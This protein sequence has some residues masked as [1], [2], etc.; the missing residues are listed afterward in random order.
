MDY[1]LEVKHPQK[2]NIEKYLGIFFDKKQVE[3]N[4]TKTNS[5][6]PM[7]EI[8]DICIRNKKSFRITKNLIEQLI[9]K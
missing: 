2:K 3:L 4:I 7:V 1:K 9:N 5:T 8:Q 6:I